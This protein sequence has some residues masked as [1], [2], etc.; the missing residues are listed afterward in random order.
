MLWVGTADRGVDRFHPELGAFNH[1][2]NSPS[3]P[4]SLVDNMIKSLH[5]DRSGVPWVGTMSGLARLDAAN[6]TFKTYAHN[7]SNPRSIIDNRVQTIYEDRSGTLWLGMY[8]DGLDRFDRKTGT[9]THFRND[10]KNP[11]SLSDNGVYSLLED[12][13]G[14]F[15]VGTYGNGLNLMDRASGTF[16][17]FVPNDSVP[18]SLGAAGVWALHEDREG[19]LWVGTA[20]GG[21]NRFNRDTKTFTHFAPVDGDSTSLSNPLVLTIHEDRTGT[22]WVGTAAGLNKLDRATGKFRQY[23]QK[24]GLS[25]DLILGI[26]EDGRGR[27]WISTSKGLSRFD[28]A[29]D[30]FRNFFYRDGLQG[31][32]FNQNAYARSPVTGEMYFGGGNGFNEFHPDSVRDNPYVP[33]VVFSAFRRYNTDD[34]EGK[35]IEEKGISVRPEITLSYKDNLA[36]FQFAALNYYNPGRNQYSYKLEGYSDNW[37]QLGSDHVATFTNLDGGDYT[38]RVRG[39]NNDGVWNDEGATLAMTVTPPWWKSTWAYVAY[40]ILAIGFLYGVR[41]FEINQRE[42]KARIRESELHAKAVE[43]EKRALEAENERQTKELEDARKLQLSML[44]RE[45][46]KFPGYQVAVFMKT[47][48]E[49]GGDYYDFSTGEGPTLNVAFGDATGHGMQAGTIVT[50]MKGLFLSDA[51]RFDITDVLQ[52][53]QPGHQ[54]DP[55]GPPFHGLYACEAQGKFRIFVECGHAPSLPPQA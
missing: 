47:A 12:S 44:P 52:P 45:I 21:L 29:T 51:S 5:V 7:P 40:A 18:G 34:E 38:L 4:T 48:T 42:Q 49:V 37:I 20:G 6:G 9:F 53:L 1:Y 35:A 16:T 46:P 54:R 24:D 17:A 27:L 23:H 3:D 25:N 28:P 22:L 32:E 41:Q 10:P 33:P 13:K 39:S 43:A 19:T 31:D 2:N 8:A 30:T 11:R 50:L 14:N 15:W 26:L 36:I 55:P